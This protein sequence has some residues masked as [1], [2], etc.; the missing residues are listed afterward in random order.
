MSI[1]KTTQ[2]FLT[3]NGIKLVSDIYR[4]NTSEKLPVLLMRQ[5]Y[6][7]AIASTVVYGHPRW[8]ANHGYIVVI[9]DVRGRG[10]SEG[11]FRL[12][13][14]EIEDGYDTLDW[15]AN[16]EGSNGNVGMYGFSYQGM[17]QLYAAI[18]QHPALK[19][20]CPAMIGYDLYT[21]W[22][23]ENGAFCYQLNLA[24]AIQLAAETAR[25]K[26]DLPAYK[27][28]Y[29]ASRNLP[30]YD[31][32]ITVDE[33]L[34]KYCPSNFYYQWLSNT[35]NNE[36]WQK[37][38][39]KTYFQD[40]DLPMLHIGG[41]FDAYLRGTL[42]L[43]QE[44]KTKSKFQQCLI[45]GVWGH[46]PWGNTLGSRSFSSFANSNIDQ[47]QIAWFD[48]YLKGIE[49]NYLPKE[50]INLF[51]MGS[52]KWITK[53]NLTNK[54]NKYLY[55]KSTGLA[56]IK[57]DDGVLLVNN[58]E[59]N[60]FQEDI[61][62]QDFWRNVPSLGGHSFVPSGVFKRTE[63]DN[64][65]D[66]ITY[67]SNFLTEELEIIGDIELEIFAQSDQ[68]SFDL[69]A[70]LSQVFPDGKVYNFTQGH[71]R[72][73]QNNCEQPIKF[74]LQPT[75]IKL[76]KN[77]ALRLSISTTNFP[78]YLVN[79]GDKKNYHHSFLNLETTPLTVNI[80]SGKD[81]PSKIIFNT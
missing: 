35:E 79:T 14:S 58:Q 41:W 80:F 23:Y 49:N 45:V 22:A 4:P 54:T 65:S 51:Q 39:P 47:T 53:N 77:T 28:L 29:L 46:I 56:N 75:C 13:E 27:T 43:Y 62:V 71:I 59:N 50:N 76:E 67:T 73:L 21:D 33:A 1:I 19:T 6:G 72:I 18:S 15:I 26:R 68:Y 2:S 60:E 38:S 66:I 48:K 12:F 32:P 25:L 11:E 42:N 24:W 16:L 37:L 63:L 74:K 69:S 55:L 10:D 61:I 30:I 40:I 9:Q 5:P 81:K 7:R 57:D 34:R 64:R 70:I 78:A 44:M 17:T 20:I 31:I 8:Y 3:R 52:N 36:Y